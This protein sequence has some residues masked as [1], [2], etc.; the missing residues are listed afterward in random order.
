MAFSRRR[1]SVRFAEEDEEFAEGEKAGQK[2]K[3]GEK[4]GGVSA[5]LSGASPI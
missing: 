2:R 1:K 4:E 3:K 5:F